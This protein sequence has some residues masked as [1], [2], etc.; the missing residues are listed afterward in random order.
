MSETV[1][2][3]LPAPRSDDSSADTGPGGAGQNVSGSG[4]L[5]KARAFTRWIDR[6]SYE[7]PGVRS[8]L[9]R[10]RGRD[11]DAVPFMHRIVAAWLTDEQ[12]RDPDVQRAYYTVASLIAA[13]RRDQF[14][15]AKSEAGTGPETEGRYGRSLG[16]AFADAVAKGD[17]GI[18]E[19]SAETRLNLLSR[20]SVAGLHRHLP[21]AVQ[22]LRDK[23]VDV[24]WAQLLVDLSRWRRHCDAIKRR[25]LQDYYRAR[26]ADGYKRA[27][28]ADEEA[29]A[30]L[31]GG[32]EHSPV[33]G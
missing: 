18:R 10:G 16:A 17:A 3:T 29:V 31:A 7:D 32:A 26:Q 13:Q 23:Q 6:R 30:A 25:W 5:Q 15:A 9:R 11:L 24:D 22:Q 21:G 12:L 27:R 14:A 20:Q 19:S 1:S 4:G 8:A 2:T 28:H 33:G